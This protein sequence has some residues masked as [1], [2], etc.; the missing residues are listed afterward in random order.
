MEDDKI[1]RVCSLDWD[2]PPFYD[3]Y[4]DNDNLVEVSTS[5]SVCFDVKRFLKNNLFSKIHFLEN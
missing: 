5:L 2:S 1:E 3:V 4:S